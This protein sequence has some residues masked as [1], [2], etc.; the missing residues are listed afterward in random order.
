MRP[1]EIRL[2]HMLDAI[3]EAL[4]FTGDKTREDI[5]SNRILSLALVQLLEIIGEAANGITIEFR[6]SHPEVPW[7]SMIRMRHRLIHGY[8]D[9]DLDIVW[10]TIVADLPPLLGR[11]EVIV[12]NIEKHH[13]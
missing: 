3:R 1:D 5:E 12:N 7:D 4:S 8:F 11:L 2:R 13:K 9:V 6:H 10:Q